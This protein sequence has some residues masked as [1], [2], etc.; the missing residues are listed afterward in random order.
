MIRITHISTYIISSTVS[1]ISDYKSRKLESGYSKATILKE[2]G[3]LRRVFSIA[4]NEWELC[5]ENPV[6]RVLKNLGRVDN[7]RV[8]YLSDEE[9]RKLM[10]VL[11]SWL[12]PIVIMARQTG[13]RRANLLQLVWNDV[14]FGNSRIIITKTKNGEPIGMPLTETALRVLKDLEEKRTAESSFVFCDNSGKPYS[15]AMVSMAF[16]RA[17]RAAGVDNFHYHDLRHDFASNLVQGNV[18]IFKVSKLL[19]HK[20]LRMTLRY[21]HLAP[22]NL[23]DAVKVLDEKGSGYVLATV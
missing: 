19:G 16:Q 14:D 1:V 11:P 8:R 4:K 21:C 20:D 7:K 23:R 22:E 17:C 12:R 5:R 13:L 10:E 2:L 15:L 3:L 18:D 9:S 6:G